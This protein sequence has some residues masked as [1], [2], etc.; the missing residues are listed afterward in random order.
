MRLLLE[1]SFNLSFTDICAG[2]LDRLDAGERERLNALMARL[3]QGDPVQYV[4]GYAP[5][6]GRDFSVRQGVLIPRPETE[7]L[8]EWIVSEEKN[9]FPLSRGIKGVSPYAGLPSPARRPPR[10]LDIGTGSGCIAVTL[11]LDIP[12]AQVTA[13]DISP[14]ALQIARDNAERLGADVMFVER[15]VLAAPQKAESDSYDIIVSNPPYICEQEA[16]LME[17][18]VLKHEPHTALFVPDDDPLL[19]YRHIALHARQMLKTDGLL[20]LEINP[21]YA[22]QTKEMLEAKGFTD[23]SIRNDQFG[24]QRMIKARKQAVSPF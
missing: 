2:A 16:K 23:I 10:I 11:A 4:T 18:N 8:C 21:A 15:D 13:W 22:L 12:H 7:E 20:Y 17:D 3:I 19:F 1:Y 9:R 5:F 14:R 24:K 6:C